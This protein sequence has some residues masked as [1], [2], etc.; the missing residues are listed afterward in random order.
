MEE[1]GLLKWICL[2]LA[3]AKCSVLVVWD[4]YEITGVVDICRMLWVIQEPS[5]ENVPAAVISCF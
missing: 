5:V 4:V 2:L 1:W 3:A